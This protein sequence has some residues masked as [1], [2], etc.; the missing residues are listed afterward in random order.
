MHLL[1]RADSDP[2]I[3]AGHVMRSLAL[4]RRWIAG[5]GSATLLGR[6]DSERLR[7]RVA[8]TRVVFRSLEASLPAA[9]DLKQTMG[10]LTELRRDGTTWAA[11]DG[12]AFDAEYHAEIRRRGFP[13]L[14]IDDLADRPIYHADIVLNQNL[15]AEHLTYRGDA[16]TRWLLGARYALL[17]PEFDLW[18]DREP[19]TPVVARR[20]LVTVGGAD[21][22]GV[23]AL[24][25]RALD[26]VAIEDLEITVV[27]GPA[28]RQAVVEQTAG[29]RRTCHLLEDVRDMASVMAS[30]DLAVTGAGST[31]WE[32]AFLG[33]PAI[34]IELSDN[35]R[36][37]A[38][39]LAAA[40]AVENAGPVQAQDVSALASRIHAL[41][42]DFE[43]RRT[44]TD[45]GRR[46]VDGQG[47]AR[48]I[49]R[50]GLGLP[51]L[52]LRRATDTDSRA[53]WTM[54]NEPSV[55]QQSFNPSP[56]AWPT[57]VTWF[58]R[59]SSSPAA[60]MWVM[61]G[62]AALAGQIRYEAGPDGA[63]IGITVA[64]KFRGVGIAARL[65]ASTWASACRELGTSRAR[66]VVFATNDASK[67]AFRE[68]GFAESGGLQMIR[69]HECHVFTKLL[70]A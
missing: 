24:I 37:P 15:G 1:L 36:L 13:L 65:L 57:H 55:R 32:L 38:R 9:D 5:G 70:D 63:E 7:D 59:I 4:A 11:V 12:Y 33:L 6:V 49:S 64:P 19:V 14:V 10:M 27:A 23:T 50:L 26:A 22:H 20:I 31:C 58:E 51:S 21:P 69:G 48:V 35:Q 42:H 40:G 44:M 43:G 68:A 47:A 61:A 16:D 28:A 60:R 3:G 52:T 34:V 54:A 46:L 30:M 39:S 62:E 17:Q 53:L 25:L 8:D 41:C 45:A 66:G 67:A 29:S 2:S 56:I 18:R